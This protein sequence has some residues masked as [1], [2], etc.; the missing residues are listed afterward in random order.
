MTG[1]AAGFLASSLYWLLAYPDLI[2]DKTAG[3]KTIPLDVI[4]AI[5]TKLEDCGNKLT[6]V[7]TV[8]QVLIKLLILLLS[9]TGLVYFLRSRMFKK[10]RTWALR[11]LIGI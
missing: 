3:E 10:G 7:N 6:R 5:R 1:V 9:V 11:F 2:T 4:H 8:S